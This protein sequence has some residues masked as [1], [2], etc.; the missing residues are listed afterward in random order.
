VRTQCCASPGRVESRTDFV[1]AEAIADASP[2]RERVLRA[3]ET[4]VRIAVPQIAHARRFP[5]A[6]GTP[7]DPVMA[8]GGGAESGG[9]ASGNWVGWLG[10][11]D[12]VDLRTSNRL[13]SQRTFGKLSGSRALRLAAPRENGQS[14]GQRGGI[15]SHSEA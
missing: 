9:A 13:T 11:E 14:A 6:V 4:P 10:G 7:T 1:L 5:E 2:S 8:R 15:N 3:P 12:Q